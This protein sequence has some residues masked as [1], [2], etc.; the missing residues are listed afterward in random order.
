MSKVLFVFACFVCSS[1]GRRVQNELA[2]QSFVELRAGWSVA[3]VLNQQTHIGVSTPSQATSPKA[4]DV[5][6]NNDVIR[7]SEAHMSS[8][9]LPNPEQMAEKIPEAESYE[10]PWYGNLRFN[11]MALLGATVSSRIAL[12]FRKRAQRAADPSMKEE[13]KSSGFDFSLFIC[14][15]L[16]YL[17]N[18]YYNITNKLAL[19]AAGGS[20]GV[21]LTIATMQLGVGS[22]Y[23]LFLW[24]APDARERPKIT[25]ADW[26][27]SLPVAAAAAASHAATV[28]SIGAGA[29][30]FAQIVKASEPAF[31]ALVGTLFYSAKVSTAKWL[32]LVPVIGG[33]CLASLGE[34]DFAVAALV[35]GLAANVT[36][37]I[38]GNENSKLMGAEG[39][40]DRFGSV[41]NIF[42][43]TI[44]NMFLMLIPVVVLL[45]GSK[46]GAF[47]S[48]LKTSTILKT[49]LLASG[50]WFFLY[51]ELATL[52]VKKT[53]AVTQSVLN[54]AKRVIVIVVVALVLGESL[55][56]I[57]LVGCGIGIGGVFLYSIIDKLVAKK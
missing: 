18:Y 48:T 32:S 26:K 31:A 44:I 17:G 19:N 28:Y 3:N 53:G 38:K 30:S 34:L 52:V 27:A 49:N 36:A 4:V 22:I 29:V 50:L 1:Q 14:V 9:S 40:K 51:N 6:P 45:E 12:S 21:P 7:A 54:T 8:A 23:A 35:A 20:A 11:A 15:A 42:A 55:G 10:Q 39:I 46:Y 13:A 2:S 56:M 57:K 33:V 25:I 24:L 47:F 41:G 16:W 43:V 5:V 37:G